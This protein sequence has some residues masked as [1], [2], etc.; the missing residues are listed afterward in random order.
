M[1]HAEGIEVLEVR[2]HRRKLRQGAL[3]GNRFRILIREFDAPSGAVDSRVAA[4]RERGVPNYF[5]EQRFGRDASNLARA[6]ELFRGA[7]RR[8]PAHQRGLWLSAA[9]SQLFNEVLAE[10]VRRG[11][12]DRPR[13][14]DC[15]QLDGSRS[16]FAATEIDHV[17]EA[18]AKSMDLHPSGPLWGAG[19]LPST[20]D[21]QALEDGVA[22]RFPAW[23]EGLAAFGMDQQRRSLRLPLSGLGATG[24]SDGLELTFALPAGSYATAVL[25]ELVDWSGDDASAGR[26]E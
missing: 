22:A 12:W 18:R 17:L 14:G 11:D 7:R 24:L 9:R 4:L 5:G 6:E 20:G 21:I 19:S 25:R 3:S 15:L 1:L 23:A 13:P 10:R 2:P 8:V 16:F 26:S